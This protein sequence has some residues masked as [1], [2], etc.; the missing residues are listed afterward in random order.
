MVQ[1]HTRSKVLRCGASALIIA[2]VIALGSTGPSAADVTSP[3]TGSPHVDPGTIPSYVLFGPIHFCITGGRYESLLAHGDDTHVEY[4][5][6]DFDG[7]VV[8][9]AANARVTIRGTNLAFDGGSVPYGDYPFPGFGG[10]TLTGL[11]ASGAPMNMTLWNDDGWG[12]ILGPPLTVPP[13]Q[14]EIEVPGLALP[15]LALLSALVSGT[16]LASLDRRRATA[17]PRSVS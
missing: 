11:T 7:I 12:Y 6:G 10:A 8:T 13:P 2:V 14:P 5:D 1:E 16:G 9:T 15:S 17:R 4:V 3:C